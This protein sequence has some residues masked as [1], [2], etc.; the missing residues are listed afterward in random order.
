MNQ[1]NKA[2]TPLV[3][4][5]GVILLCAVFYSVHLMGGLYARYSTTMMGSDA[6][7]VAKID[8]A[9]NYKFSG[10]GELGDIS[11]DNNTVFALIEEFSVENTGEVSYT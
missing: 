1:L 5:I 10:Y 8:C 6:A 4:R 9:V 2:N 3:F 11:G 7:R